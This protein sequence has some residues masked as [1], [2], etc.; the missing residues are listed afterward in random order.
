MTLTSAQ[1]L[2]LKNAIAAETNPAFVISRTAGAVGAMADFFQTDSTF[3]VWRTNTDVGTIYDAVDWAKLTPTDA[4]DATAT[5][6]NRALLCQAKQ[7]NLQ[8]MLQGQDRI[9]ATRLK[10]RQGLQDS[11]QAVPSGVAGASL[12]AGWTAVKTAMYRPATLGEKLFA[13]GTGTTG[14]PG[15]LT[16][17]GSIRL[18]DVV[19]AINS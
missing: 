12:D 13:T 3:I 7:I 1:T 18:E 15:L 5:Y 8:I 6:T 10:I 2:I 11:L 16:F 14:V 19:I 17:E 4:P 9:N